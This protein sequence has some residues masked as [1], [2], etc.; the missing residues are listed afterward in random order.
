MSRPRPKAEGEEG[1]EDAVAEVAPADISGL[2]EDAMAVVAEKR[3]S[4]KEAG[5]E[6]GDVTA[7]GSHGGRR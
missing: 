7:R 2:I 5:E 4:R 1:A 6:L 3:K